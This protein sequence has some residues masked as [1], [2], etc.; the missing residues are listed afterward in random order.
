MYIV[1]NEGSDI[2]KQ[3][4]EALIRSAFF[5]TIHHTA[6]LTIETLDGL[7]VFLEED[8]D[9]DLEY[10]EDREKEENTVKSW[11]ALAKWFNDQPELGDPVFVSIDENGS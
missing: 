11:Q 6:K 5:N 1:A 10:E 8:G 9:L 3:I 4:T 2:S 7:V